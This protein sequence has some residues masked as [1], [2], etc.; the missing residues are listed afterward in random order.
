VTRVVPTAEFAS[1]VFG[2]RGV[3]IDDAAEAF[4]EAS[5]LYPNV[6]P[7]RLEASV[8]LA[9]SPELQQ[10]V[11]RSSRLHEHRPGLDLEPG[12]LPPAPF[13]TLLAE[14][15]SEVAAEARA[16]TLTE[17]SAIL[18]ASYGRA[19]AT[20]PNAAR[21]A[22]P[23]AGALYPL[24]LYVLALHVAELEPAAWHYHPFR[25]RLERLAPVDADDTRAAVV[26]QAVLETAAAVL[27][28]TAVFWRTRFKYGLRG[29]RFALL[30]AGHVMQNAVLAATAL[31]LSALPLGGF[32]DRRLDALVGADGLDE[33]CVYALVLG[34]RA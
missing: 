11:A 20:H 6:A 7:G 33:A 1:T 29:Y 24:E 8:A 34:G 18:G 23:S 30:E 3:E 26:D 19:R 15:R 28:V 31:G 5:R 27:V 25:H 17:L 12:T 21:R 32:F 22:V 13:A 16:L 10:T 9:R 2:A 14:R 4:H